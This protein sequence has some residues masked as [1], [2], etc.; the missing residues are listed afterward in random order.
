MTRLADRTRNPQERVHHKT[1]PDP[2]NAHGTKAVR[3]KTGETWD[4]LRG[5]D[6]ESAAAIA[7]AEFRAGYAAGWKAAQKSK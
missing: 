5:V 7:N 2:W 6:A 4:F 1:R 3:H